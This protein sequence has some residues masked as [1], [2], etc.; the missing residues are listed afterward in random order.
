MFSLTAPASPGGA[1]AETVLYRFTGGE[2][3]GY[4]D[5]LVLGASGALYGTTFG[6]GVKTCDNGCG[7][8]FA[9]RP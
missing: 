3:G 5:G 6:A 8:V 1:W 7:T 4:P 2:D 9:L